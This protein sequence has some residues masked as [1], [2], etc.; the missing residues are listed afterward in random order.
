[1]KILNAIVYD[2]SEYDLKEACDEF[3]SL[4]VLPGISEIAL[5]F[6]N[7]VGLVKGNKHLMLEE[8]TDK[9]IILSDCDFEDFN[10]NN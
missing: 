5:I 2:K 1:M 9:I 7:T 6:F 4:Y 8:S 3:V 10:F